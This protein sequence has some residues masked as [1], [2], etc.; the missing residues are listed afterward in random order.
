[1]SY[2]GNIGRIGALAVALGVGYAVADAPAFAQPADS[3]ASG[4]S[5]PA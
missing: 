2:A 5:G 3:S 1:M 4:E